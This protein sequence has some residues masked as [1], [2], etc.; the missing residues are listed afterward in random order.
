MF[1]KHTLLVYTHGKCA[2]VTR[3]YLSPAVVPYRRINDNRLVCDCHLAWFAH[4]LRR[5]PT[6][7]LFT[8][9]DHPLHLRSA[10]ISE[11]QDSDFKCDGK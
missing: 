7:A 9:C 10:E 11:L 2:E 8:E 3:C 6:L 4:W 1:L 5:N